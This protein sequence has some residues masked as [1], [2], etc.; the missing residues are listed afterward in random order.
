MILIFL[1][2]SG[3]SLVTR[4]LLS[5]GC[6][7]CPGGGPGHG[8]TADNGTRNDLTPRLSARRAPGVGPAPS[9]QIQIALVSLGI[10]HEP[11]KVG[12]LSSPGEGEEL[13]LLVFF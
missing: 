10:Q 6:A 2:C 9:M 7:R 5:G 4:T 3:K 1:L 13:L 12:Y 8:D 11:C